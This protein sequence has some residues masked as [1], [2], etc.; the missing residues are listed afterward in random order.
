VRAL[1]ALV[2]GG[3]PLAGGPE[4]VGAAA[5]GVGARVLD[6]ELPAVEV[7]VFG[8]DEGGGGVFYGEEVDEGEAEKSGVLLAKSTGKRSRMEVPFAQSG[9]FEGAH[10]DLSYPLVFGLC[11]FRI[12]LAIW[13]SVHLFS[14]ILIHRGVLG[15]I[16]AF[17]IPRPMGI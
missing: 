10:A 7:V 1:L 5:D 8:V 17:L 9:I 3:G 11:F 4:G 13:G 15:D 12:R 2:R 14:S 6:E 16:F